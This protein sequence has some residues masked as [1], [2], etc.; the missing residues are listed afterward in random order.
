MPVELVLGRFMV[1]NGPIVG[2]A[3]HE[4]SNSVLRMADVAAQDSGVHGEDPTTFIYIETH[5]L[6]RC[7]QHMSGAQWWGAVKGVALRCTA[8]CCEREKRR[9]AD[10]AAC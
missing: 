6:N 9:Q 5:R 1:I 4:M 8:G 3:A 2:M 7:G 10:Q